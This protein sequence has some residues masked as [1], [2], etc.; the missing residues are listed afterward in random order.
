MIRICYVVLTGI[1]R[2]DSVACLILTD[3]CPGLQFFA[4]SLHA[5]AGT[6][7]STKASQAGR[8]LKTR[9]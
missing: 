2:D 3:I 8:I 7:V 4:S 1:I 5:C 9:A 6:T